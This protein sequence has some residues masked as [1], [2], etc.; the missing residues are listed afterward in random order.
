MLRLVEPSRT[1]LGRRVCGS[2]NQQLAQILQMVG[3]TLMTAQDPRT[4]PPAMR[5][6]R[7]LVE[8]GIV[9]VTFA[10]SV[11]QMQGTP[12]YTSLMPLL[13]AIV[14]RMFEAT[15]I[16]APVQHAARTEFEAMGGFWTGMAPSIRNAAAYTDYITAQI[17]VLYITTRKRTM[18]TEGNRWFPILLTSCARTRSTRRSIWKV[19][20]L[21][22]FASCRTPPQQPC[23]RVL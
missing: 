19:F 10:Q 3:D 15:C 7:V 22:Q 5:S 20:Y 17:K 14:P 1:W 18:L 23:P 6:F 8:M 4:W 13:Q 21:P 16:E 11:N 2:F 12:R 9:I